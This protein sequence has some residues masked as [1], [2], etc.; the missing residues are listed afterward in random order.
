MKRISID[1]ELRRKLLNLDNDLEL[2][3]EEGKVLAR[4]VRSTP[5]TDLDSWVP[6]TPEISPEEIQRRLNSNEPR[7]TTEQVIAKLRSL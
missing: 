3:D 6:L 4:V 7:Y 5:G 1:E 2:C